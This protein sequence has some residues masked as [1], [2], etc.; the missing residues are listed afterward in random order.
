MQ[1]KIKAILFDSGRVL[2]GPTTGHW[3]IT[4]NFFNYV[5]KQDFM[6]IPKVRRETAFNKAGD[7]IR[8][9]REILTEEEEYTHFLEYYRIFFRELPEL[10]LQEDRVKLVAKDLV[11]NYNK[12]RFYKDVAKVIPELSLIYKLAVVSDAWPSLEKVFINAGY[13]AYFSS[14]VI[15]SKIASSK[16]EPKMFETALNELKVQPEN[17][18]FI[19]DSVFNCDG[20]KS[21]GLKTLVLSRDIKLYTYNKLTCKNH[22]VIKNLNSLQK[23]L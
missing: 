19:D 2:N 4:P 11:F 7:Y 12:Y 10:N 18:L 17:A 14:F 21:L 22:K 1:E 16:P 20:A 13:R 15:S 6:N 8:A 3:F 23:Y 9:Q 5:D